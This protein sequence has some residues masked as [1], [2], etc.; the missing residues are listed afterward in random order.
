MP[1]ITV[2]IDGS[3]NAHHALIWAMHEA[4]Q[5]KLPLTVLTVHETLATYWTGPPSR[6]PSMVMKSWLSRLGSQLRRLWLQVAKDIGA[7]EQAAGDRLRDQ[8]L[9]GSAAHRRLC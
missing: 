9:R 8:R 7:D 4:A 6:S 2:G 3:D 5:R 1:G